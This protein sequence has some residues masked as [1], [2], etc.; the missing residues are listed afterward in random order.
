M[1]L[2]PSDSGDLSRAIP[3][4]REMEQEGLTVGRV[5]PTHWITY[6]R[7]AIAAGVG[8]VFLSM[9]GDKAD[10]VLTGV[11]SRDTVTGVSRFVINTGYAA[12]G[13]KKAALAITMV[14]KMERWAASKGA[15]MIL[16]GSIVWSDRRSAR[17]FKGLGYKLTE[18]MFVKGLK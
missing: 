8:V 17:I 11:I 1:I 14:R 4:L 18:E 13:C 3:L 5:N 12:K 15:K 6:W 10:G 16:G 2:E 9:D 7:V